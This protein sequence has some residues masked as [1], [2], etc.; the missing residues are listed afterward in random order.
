MDYVVTFV[1]RAEIVTADPR[2]DAAKALER[3]LDSVMEELLKLESDTV[4]TSDI[5][6]TLATGEVEL[7][8]VVR[9]DNVADGFTVGMST[10][11]CAVHAAGGYTPDWDD[12]ADGGWVLEYESSRQKRL[13]L[14]DA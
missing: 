11:R 3:H 13:D 1:G 12:D 5:S 4:S 2:V 14:V 8:V 10:I 7:S 9:A 6:A